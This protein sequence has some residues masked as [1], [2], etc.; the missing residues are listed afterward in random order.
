MTCNCYKCQA[1]TGCIRTVAVNRTSL[2]Q[3]GRWDPVVGE[4]VSNDREFRSKLSRGRDEQSAKLGLDVKLE[5]VD[6]RDHDALASLHGHDPA[7]RKELAE[8]T[9]RTKAS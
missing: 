9:K 6:A 5:T 8:R 4:Y 3:S 1:G 7:E 2:R